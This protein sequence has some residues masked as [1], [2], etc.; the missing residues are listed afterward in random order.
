LSKIIHLWSDGS[1]INN[2]KDKGLG[3][4]GYVLLYGDF[5]DVDINTEYCDE[6]YILTGYEGFTNTTNQQMEIMAIAEGLKRLR[7]HDLPI[8][9]YS[10]SAY[11]INCFKEGW[12]HSWRQNGWKNSQ[13]KPVA[14]KE[15]WEDLINT[16]EDNMLMVNFNKVKS[17][18]GIHYNEIADS[19]AYKGMDEKREEKYG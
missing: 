18:I 10:D 12:H 9:I 2:G 15:Q 19:L 17:H 16:I 13:K 5:E 14:N 7:N 8:E 11:V 6:K 4:Y 3:G 1:S